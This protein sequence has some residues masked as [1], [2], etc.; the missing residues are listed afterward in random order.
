MLAQQV[1]SRG[2]MMQICLDFA[3]V[4]CA[5]IFQAIMKNCPG[6]VLV[7]AGRGGS[8]RVC[9]CQE[10]SPGTL[11]VPVPG[12]ALPCPGA[13]AISTQVCWGWLG[14]DVLGPLA[15]Q[16]WCCSCCA[17]PWCTRL[18]WGCIS[19]SDDSLGQHWARTKPELN[20]LT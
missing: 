11:P 14:S 2:K 8:C 16:P 15:G 19:G 1:N 12:T 9:P 5:E 20:I 3:G 4:Y 10:S 17:W 6:F 7:G 18:S 13:E